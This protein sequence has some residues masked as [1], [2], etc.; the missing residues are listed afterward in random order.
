MTNAPKEDDTVH[1]QSSSRPIHIPGT[2]KFWTSTIGALRDLIARGLAACGITPNV[3]T[4]LGL[5]ATCATAVCF[6][7]GGGYLPAQLHEMGLPSY[8]MIGGIFL[9]VAC[10]MDMLDGA[11]AR[12]GKMATPLGAVLDSSVD[13]LSDAA[14][15]IAL[16]GHFALRGNLTYSLFAIIA[17]THAMLISYIKARG[18][19]IIPDCGV[20]YWARPERCVA[21]LSGAFGAGLCG[22][23][24]SQAIL[25]AFTVLRRL[26]WFHAALAAKE[27]GKPLPVKKPPTGLSGLLRPWRYPRGSLPFD[28]VS[29]INIA[30]AA[31]APYLHPIFR[32]ES[33]PLRSLLGS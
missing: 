11:V 9:L 1:S 2:R 14:I 7:R 23:L 17:L 27:Q 22:T 15:Y 19:C 24:W 33:D 10:A 3:L 29:A 18:E 31:I 26:R 16:V 30:F 5:L 32:P 6:F 28:V 13:R 12:I 21:I 8:P 4:L 20:G 25:P